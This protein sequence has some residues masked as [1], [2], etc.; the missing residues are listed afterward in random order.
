[1][2][3]INTLVRCMMHLG[4]R[5]LNDSSTDVVEPN[6]DPTGQTMGTRFLV[7]NG[8]HEFADL[9]ELIVNHIQA[10]ARK[11]EELMA[12]EKYKHKEDELRKSAKLLHI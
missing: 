9:D 10:I 2:A 5:P 1:M 6:A 8:R 11:V 4:L 3:S 12:H 7:E